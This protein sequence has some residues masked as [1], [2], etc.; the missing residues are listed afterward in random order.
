[1]CGIER[2]PPPPPPP[3]PPPSV[4]TMLRQCSLLSLLVL[5][6]PHTITDREEAGQTVE[7][8]WS[9]YR[10]LLSDGGFLYN[11]SFIVVNDY[12]QSL[13]ETNFDIDGDSNL[14]EVPKHG[15]ENTLMGMV[16]ALQDIQSKGDQMMSA[17]TDQKKVLSRL[18]SEVAKAEE[19]LEEAI[20]V[21]AAME[22]KKNEAENE[23]KTAERSTRTLSQ[24]KAEIKDELE[25]LHREKETS[26]VKLE[27]LK[28][29]L[30]R[31]NKEMKD[32][33]NLRQSLQL[34]TSVTSAH[35]L[36]GPV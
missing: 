28:E 27:T 12:D 36:A 3:P 7:D 21:T 15:F 31:V 8:R 29:E 11:D 25:S 35:F 14:E 1:M 24:R 20:K 26:L 9:Q 18:R 16:S 17:I 13:D 30:N 23:I 33:S 32:L 19:R 10:A 6:T 4:I 2:V 22:M 34:K 5:V